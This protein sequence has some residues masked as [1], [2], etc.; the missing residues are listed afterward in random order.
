MYEAV[1]LSHND[2]E[3]TKYISSCCSQKSVQLHKLTTPYFAERQIPERL[4]FDEE[5]DPKRRRGR[6]THHVGSVD[7]KQR[8]GGVRS[9]SASEER[10]A[11]TGRPVKQYSARRLHTGNGVGR[12]ESQGGPSF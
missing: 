3:G 1:N 6:D 12:A 4:Y 5:R 7:H 10:L 9:G 2:R 8:S 11:R